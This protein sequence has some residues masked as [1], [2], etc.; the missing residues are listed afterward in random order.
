MKE[1]NDDIQLDKWYDHRQHELELYIKNQNY[2]KTIAVYNNKGLH[3]VVE[4]E[5]GI[6]DYH[7]KALEYLKIAPEEVL[8]KLREV[9]PEE[10]RN[11][12]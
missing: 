3:A 2:A 8:E 12:N 10:L 6:K 7:E 4:Q 1:F 5:L 11:N 9:F